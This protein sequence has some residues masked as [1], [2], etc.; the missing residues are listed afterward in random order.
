[1]LHLKELIHLLQ[2]ITASLQDNNNH[3]LTRKSINKRKN[4]TKDKKNQPTDNLTE[5]VELA[6]ARK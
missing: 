6:E 1:V 4:P 5:E 2:E 3:V